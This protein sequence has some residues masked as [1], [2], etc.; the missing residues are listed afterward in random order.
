M[1]K[2][3]T[4]I[5]PKLVEKSLVNDKFSA[6]KEMFPEVMTEVK[7]DDGKIVYGIDVEK[8]AEVVSGKA[9]EKFETYGLNWI[10]KSQ[11]IALSKEAPAGALRPCVEDSI[12]FNETENVYIEGDNLEV[13]KLLR[14]TY[15]GKIKMIYIDPPY[16]TGNDFIYKDNFKM[17]I[18]QYKLI[19]GQKDKDGNQ[20]TTEKETA[21]YRHSD[22]LNMMYPRLKIARELLA[23]DGAIFIS[24][25]D[26][27]IANLKK[28]CDEIFGESNF[29]DIFNWVKTETPEN[30]SKKSRQKI[31][32][33]LIYQKKKNS[34]RFIGI[35]KD[36]ASSNG[37]LNQSNKVSQ[38][39]FPANVVQTKIKDGIIKKGIY[40]TDVYVVEL[41][42]DTEVK[43]GI[44]VK[45]ICL[46]AKFKWTQ[47][48]L[49]QEIMSGTRI[50][51]PTIKLSPAYEKK[52]YLPEVPTNLIDSSVNVATNEN[53]SNDLRKMFDIDVFN[54]PKPYNLISYLL[55][56]LDVE[57]E[58]CIVLDFFAGSS[59]TAEA[60]FDLNQE[61]NSNKYQ[62]ILIQLDEQLEVIKKSMKEEKTK[63]IIQNA[64]DF[65]SKRDLPLKLTEIGKERIRRAGKRIKEEYPDK[66]IDTGFRVYKLDSSNINEEIFKKPHEISVD[67]L[68]ADKIKADRTDLDLLTQVMLEN[69][70]ELSMPI[71]EEKID[72]HKVYSVDNDYLIA[73]FDTDIKEETF[74]K[75]LKK[76][77]MAL[78]ALKEPINDS[79]L[80]NVNVLKMQYNPD[81]EVRVL[82]YGI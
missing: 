48:K 25:D 55:K 27:E 53:A 66:N 51:I 52:E 57:N 43:N 61:I 33:I 36:S 50:L 32:Y 79:F 26:N 82:E 59:T 16:N 10:G 22:W 77:N 75:L 12:N 31:E 5:V 47:S 19:T 69:S 39:I 73:C 3:P 28:I 62:F 58:K 20:L 63:K 41:L 37:L 13:L 6:L 40:G 30:M 8:L 1:A 14:S 35:R 65:L 4:V 7:D 78:I 29:I 44:F 81:V 24:I 46:K 42:E 72:G 49:E 71:K 70:I 68:I 74:K 21:G 67:K 54:Y 80:T 64:I 9:V 34:D 76:E 23:D 45:K 18:E 60:I 11:C 17:P 38:L 56:F 15:K 2:K